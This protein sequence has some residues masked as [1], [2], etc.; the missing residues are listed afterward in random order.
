MPL[1]GII[2]GLCQTL[3]SVKTR[4][5]GICDKALSTLFLMIICNI[6]VKTLMKDKYRKQIETEKQREK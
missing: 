3:K 6:T 1:K 4:P 2:T 5:L